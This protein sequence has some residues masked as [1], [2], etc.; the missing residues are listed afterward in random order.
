MQVFWFWDNKAAEALGSFDPE[1]IWNTCQANDTLHFQCTQCDTQDKMK[2][3][4]THWY[5]FQ[6]HSRRPVS[7]GIPQPPNRPP[8]P[9]V[10]RSLPRPPQV[11]DYYN[12]DDNGDDDDIIN[13]DNSDDNDDNGDDNDVWLH[14]SWNPNWFYTCSSSRN[15]WHFHRDQLCWKKPFECTVSFPYDLIQ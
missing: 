2:W 9:P 15:W 7:F 4:K 11:A 3:S 5:S 10:H 1:Q 13:D 8:P 14:R 12:D 6:I